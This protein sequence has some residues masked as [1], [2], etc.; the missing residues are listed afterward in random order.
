MG[1]QITWALENRVLRVDFERN[2]TTEEYFAGVKQ[3]NDLVVQA[4]PR[5]IG[6]IL[7]AQ[8]DGTIPR[9][10][11]FDIGRQTL[12]IMPAN[13]EAIAIVDSG[14]LSRAMIM[15]FFRVFREY[16]PNPNIDVII[17]DS[18]EEALQRLD[19]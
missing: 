18:V 3:A 12:R 2:W 19:R 6:V 15:T 14:L 13:V 1:I 10:N 8:P 5:P 11:L 16:A 7:N 17:V 9:L 4:D